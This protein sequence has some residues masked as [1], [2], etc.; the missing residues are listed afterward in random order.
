MMIK[1]IQP[2]EREMRER[3]SREEATAAYIL[4]IS[5][6]QDVGKGPKRILFTL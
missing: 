2:M 6:Q 5:K 1:T 3:C 4:N